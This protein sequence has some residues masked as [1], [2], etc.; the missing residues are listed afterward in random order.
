MFFVNFAVTVCCDPKESYTCSDVENVSGGGPA[1]AAAL[2]FMS[3]DS[4][5]VATGALM[6]PTGTLMSPGSE[7]VSRTPLL[8]DQP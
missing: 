5:L 6:L 7:F 3:N 1:V 2:R 8:S 4:D